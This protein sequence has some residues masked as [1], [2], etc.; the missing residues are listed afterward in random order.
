MI[1]VHRLDQGLSKCSPHAI[2]V[3]YAL[4]RN[5]QKMQIHGPHLLNQTLLQWDL[6]PVVY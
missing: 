6:Q 5:L 1:C 4:L 3:A 2:A